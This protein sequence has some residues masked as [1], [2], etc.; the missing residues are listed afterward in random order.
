MHSGL[1]PV[2]NAYF[3]DERFQNSF[4]YAWIAASIAQKVTDRPEGYVICVIRIDEV[5]QPAKVD[6]VPSNSSQPAGF[7]HSS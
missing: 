5:F 4:Y 2:D 7:R 3:N 1:P 6:G